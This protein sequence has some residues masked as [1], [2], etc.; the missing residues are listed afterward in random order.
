MK[1]KSKKLVVVL[2]ILIL[3]AMAVAYAAVSQTLTI[4][5]TARVAADVS[6]VIITNIQPAAT[7]AD[8]IAEDTED[9][10]NFDETSATFDVTLGQPGAF[11]EYTVTIEN[12][13]NSDA[14]LSAI[15]YF[16]VDGT[17]QAMELS[18]INAADPAGI[19]FTVTEPDSTT[20]AA[21]G[22]TTVVV[23]ATWNANNPD[24]DAGASKTMKMTLLYEVPDATN[25]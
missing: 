3:L 15:E 12:Q 7:N 2:V 4:T 16:L 22:S 11:A 5:G 18:A 6:K 13:G 14:D 21:G 20:L 1:N 23:R 10:F 9:S 24:I 19:E 25:P 8:N 17:E